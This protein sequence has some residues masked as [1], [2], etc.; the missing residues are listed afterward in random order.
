MRFFTVA[1]ALVGAAAA[2]NLEA[3]WITTSSSSS[4]APSCTPA[5]V[6]VTVYPGGGKS[7]NSTGTAGPT[8]TK[9]LYVNGADSLTYGAWTAILGVAAAMLL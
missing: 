7:S 3:R 8:P 5:T 9:A 2:N 6:T 4:M 1:A